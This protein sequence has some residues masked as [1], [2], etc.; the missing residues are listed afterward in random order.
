MSRRRALGLLL[1]IV[2]LLAGGCAPPLPGTQGR[3]EADCQDL[4]HEFWEFERGLA[5]SD[6][7]CK[8]ANKDP[9]Q[10]W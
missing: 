8:P 6:C 9:I 2:I 1:L 7:W 3:C 4:G 10:V 5:G